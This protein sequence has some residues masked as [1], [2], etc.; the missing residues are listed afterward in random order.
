MIL[1]NWSVTSDVNAFIAP[2]LKHYYLQ[3]NVYGNPKFEDGR[4]VI[5]SRIM[6]LNDKGDYKEAITRSGSVYQL[7]KN[8]V[9]PEAEM[10]HPNYYERLKME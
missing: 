2:E 1:K 8:D 6:E 3:G 10:Q 7:F 4:N 5:T 9:N